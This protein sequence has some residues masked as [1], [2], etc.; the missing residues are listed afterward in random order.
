M[1]Q[2]NNVK[3]L[4]QA[5][6]VFDGQELFIEREGVKIAR[7]GTGPQARTWVS[8]EPGW[9]VFDSYRGRQRSIVVEYNGVGSVQ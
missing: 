7:R 6:V 1:K 8:L 5:R 2:S 4:D 3:R 9:R